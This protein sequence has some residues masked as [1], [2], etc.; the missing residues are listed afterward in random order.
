MQPLQER[1]SYAFFIAIRMV[2]LLFGC[3]V[4]L[5]FCCLVVLLNAN[6]DNKTTRQQNDKKTPYS[7][8]IVFPL[9][10]TMALPISFMAFMTVST[11]LLR[12][13]MKRMR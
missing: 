11:P 3:L 4:V 13:A 6:T 2:V 9:I 7:T 8:Y 1:K 5:L 12:W 10:Y